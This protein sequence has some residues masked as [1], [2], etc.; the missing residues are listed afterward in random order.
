MVELR[1]SHTSGL[2]DFVSVGKALPGQRIVAEEPPP[3]LLQVE[4][5]VSCRNE[6]VVEAWMRF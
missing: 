4:P 2:L 5:A 3:A 1:R 6:N